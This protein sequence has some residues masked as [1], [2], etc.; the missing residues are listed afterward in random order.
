VTRGTQHGIKRSIDLAGAALGLVIGLPLLGLSA[1]AI[2]M[3]DQGPV[4]FCQ[5]RAGKNGRPFS[6]YKLR[7][8]RVGAE[9][10]VD[11]DPQTR[12]S[13][14]L[15]SKYR[16]DPRITRVGR[17][18]RRWSID[19]IPQFYNVLRGEMSLVGPRPE[20]ARIVS[21][22]SPQERLRLAVK[23]GV[24]GPMQVNGRANLGFE[25]RMQ[26]ELEYIDNYSIW[27]DI[28]IMLQTIGAVINGKGSY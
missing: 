17:F 25:Q 2:W 26:L 13:H 7:S 6:M 28:K 12:S 23:P 11:E 22:Y 21:Q 4:F 19:E 18:L 14:R 5:V 20:E 8:M 3:E 9:N 15:A 1:L 10:Q 24:T 27:I 16:Q